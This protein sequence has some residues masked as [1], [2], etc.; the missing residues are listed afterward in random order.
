MPIFSV[1]STFFVYQYFK[2]VTRFYNNFYYENTP[3]AL[4]KIII[5][6]HT[7]YKQLTNS[8]ILYF[9]TKR[10]TIII[11]VYSYIQKFDGFGKQ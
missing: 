7:M 1:S 3:M 11:T 9:F 2:E 4:H 10:D 6:K 8:E 5:R